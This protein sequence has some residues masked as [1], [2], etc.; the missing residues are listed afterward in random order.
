MRLIII[1]SWRLL[2]GRKWK[3]PQDRKKKNSLSEEI[4]LFWLN[5]KDLLTEWLS[6]PNRKKLKKLFLMNYLPPYKVKNLA[7]LKLFHLNQCLLI[8]K[9]YRAN[10]T[11]WDP[12]QIWILKSCKDNKEMFILKPTIW[13]AKILWKKTQVLLKGL[14]Q[15]M[16]AQEI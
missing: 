8:V 12:N 4:L 10:W 9:I 7:V 16:E 2:L 15:E 3:Q 14:S 1:R 13:S 11:K 6:K 5:L